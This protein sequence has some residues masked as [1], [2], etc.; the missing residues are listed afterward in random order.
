[1]S[2]Q[3]VYKKLFNLLL[4]TSRAE[5][6]PVEQRPSAGRTYALIH[7]S[8]S[9]IPESLRLNTANTTLQQNVEIAETEY[10]IPVAAVNAQPQS[11]W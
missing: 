11:W 2:N 1:M 8:S 7:R 5:G 3:M 6:A 10:V 9:H 4:D